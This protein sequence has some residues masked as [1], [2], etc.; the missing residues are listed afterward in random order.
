MT[1]QG[2][3]PGTDFTFGMFNG[4]PRITANANKMW[5]DAPTKEIGQMIIDLWATREA[6]TVRG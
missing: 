1:A 5:I 6:P 2:H 4:R 3:D